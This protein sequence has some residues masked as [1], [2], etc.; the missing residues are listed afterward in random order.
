M[1]VQNADVMNLCRINSRRLAAP[2]QNYL[3]FKIKN[4]LRLAVKNVD[5]QKFIGRK[6]PQAQIFWTS[7]LEAEKR[8]KKNE[9]SVAENHAVLIFYTEKQKELWKNHE[10][11]EAEWEKGDGFAVFY[12]VKVKSLQNEKQ[13]CIM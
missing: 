9:N 2:W 13:I 3:I 12:E 7:L 5:I 8:C 1:F 4:S 11:M 10:K 6:H